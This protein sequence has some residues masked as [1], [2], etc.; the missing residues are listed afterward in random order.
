VPAVLPGLESVEL[1]DRERRILWQLLSQLYAPC[2]DQAVSI[3]QCVQE[4]RPCAG[5]KPAARLLADKIK[6][7]ATP[8]QARDLYG[9]RFGPNV[10]QIEPADSPSRGPADAPVTVMVW[11]DFEC[12]HC[13]L[14]VPFLDRIIEKFSGR[15]RLVH[16]FY[17]LRQHSYAEGSARA[18]IAAQNQ[19][20]YWEMERILFAHQKE[21]TEADL[22]KY[23]TELKLDI[24]RFRA[25]MTAERTSK[26]LERDH[27]DAEKAGL[28]GT[29]LILINGREFD[30]AYF[31][32][33][34]DL[35]P[36]IAL[37]LELLSR[38]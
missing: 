36:W 25:D 20:K 28:S 18:A 23:A 24:Q 13:G 2:A 15:V 9:V 7:G 35:E 31:H 21:Q 10:K 19:G 14:A 34:P 29:P 11:S 4:A 6:E 33:E 27:A 12:P 38:R 30:S 3:Q 17:P 5:C 1:V 26:I 22:L 8:D 37:E 32:L 16:K